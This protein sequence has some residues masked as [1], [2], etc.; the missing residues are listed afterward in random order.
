[1]P[2]VKNRRFLSN[3]SDD[4]IVQSGKD[5]FDNA[6]GNWKKEF[7]GNDSPIVLELACGRGEY[8]VGLAQHFPEK[9]F[10]GVDKK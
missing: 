8:T 5:F 9:N 2:R 3:H 7:F 4:R 6:K 1:M 10:L